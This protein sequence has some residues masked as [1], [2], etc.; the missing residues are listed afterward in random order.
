MTS[1]LHPEFFNVQKSQNGKPTGLNFIVGSV[2]PWLEK[3]KEW[4]VENKDQPRPFD[5]PRTEIADN[6][7]ALLVLC[8]IPGIEPAPQFA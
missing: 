4:F 8:D 7:P 3:D 6:P 1:H 2:T 5:N